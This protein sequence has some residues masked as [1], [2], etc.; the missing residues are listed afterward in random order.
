MF[1]ETSWTFS[2]CRATK[3]NFRICLRESGLVVWVSLRVR[4]VPGS[5]PGCPLFPYSFKVMFQETSWIFSSCRV[6]KRNFLHC[7]QDSG[8]VVWLTL[9]VL[10]CQRSRVSIPGC[11]RFPFSFTAMFQETSWIFSSCRATKR[12]FRHC[13]Q[14]SGLVVWFSLRVREDPDSIPGCPLFPF[15]VMFQET[16]WNFS[17]CRVTKRNFWH[18]LRDSGLVVW[19]SL[20]VREVPGSIPGCRIFPF[21][22]N[23]MFQETSWTF[24]SCRAT[25]RNFRICLRDSGLVVWVSLRVREVPGS[26]P[27]CPLFPYSFKVMF[28]ETSWIFSSCRVTKRNFLHCLQDSGVVLWLR[29]RVLGCE[30]SR[31]SIPGCPRFPFSFT[32]MFQETSWI[33]SSCR[34]TKRNFQH[35]LQDSGLVVWFSLRVRED[36]GSITG[37]PLF[38]FNFKVL[39]QETSWNFSSCR[40]TKRNFR[41]RLRD[42]GLVVS[43]TFRVR[44]V[45]G[46]NSQLSPFPF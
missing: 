27:G 24:S 43:F 37:C 31:V 45:P 11:P 5:I 28:Q 17:S 42:S 18:C 32:A 20:L 29:L 38:P 33:F 3:R 35:C 26:I 10:G 1:Q 13:L 41:H 23:A 7:L 14:D 40:A 15:K 30:R 25:K 8:L 6:T 19:F 39:F 44:E 16:S 12:N 36:P 46:F 4:E 21:N 22:F 9:R 2:S 34:A